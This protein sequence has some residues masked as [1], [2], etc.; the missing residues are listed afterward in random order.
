MYGTVARNKI[1]L[2]DRNLLERTCDVR[3]WAMEHAFWFSLSSENTLCISLNRLMEAMDQPLPKEIFP[4]AKDW[5]AK[6]TVQNY[7]TGDERSPM[8][9]LGQLIASQSTEVRA[10][11]EEDYLSLERALK[12]AADAEDYA[13]SRLQDIRSSY[14][15]YRDLVLLDD[16]GRIVAN[17]RPELAKLYT[18]VDASTQNWFRDGMR[19]T[20]ASQFF[21]SDVAQSQLDAERETSLIY[22]AGVRKDGAREGISAGVLAT[23]FDWETEALAILNSCLPRKSDGKPVDGSVAFYTNRKH[24]IMASTCA[25]HFKIGLELPFTER[26]RELSPGESL[27]Q[28]IEFNGCRYIIGSTRTKGYREYTGLG[29]TAHVLRPM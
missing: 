2:I 8:A 24:R 3:W 17:A 23:V 25:E 6:I 10:S 18:K 26:Q 14:S 29:W 20:A 9:R 1:S 11:I 13:C 21:C 12:T 27:T 4:T 7:V 28:T 15:L 19:S 16:S 22:S 5:C